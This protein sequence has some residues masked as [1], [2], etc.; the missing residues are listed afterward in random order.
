M[1]ERE[2]EK[3]IAENQQLRAENAQNAIA[4]KKFKSVARIISHDLRSP[5]ASSA[6]CLE[7]CLEMLK[8]EDFVNKDVITFITMAEEQN[9][10]LLG[11]V[12]NLLLWSRMQID[13]VKIVNEKINLK[14]IL[15]DTISPYM[16]SCLSKG[17]NIR[18]DVE[19]VS[20]VVNKSIF[21][22]I[23]RNLFINAVKFTPKNGEINLFAKKQDDFVSVVVKDN[24]IGMTQEK[25]KKIFESIG[26]TSLGT[27]GEKGTGLG[28]AMCNEMAEKAGILISVDS[29]GEGKGSSFTISIP[30]QKK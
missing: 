7:L 14:N 2:V 28:L 5:I 27:E 9:R 19:D 17:I 20:V 30:K 10:N 16:L 11:L 29:E 3:I 24:G 23:I 22:F 4:L 6:G 21:Q 26:E 12:D 18:F 15:A 25:I 13:G 1:E 8:G